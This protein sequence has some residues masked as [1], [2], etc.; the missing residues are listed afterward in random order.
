MKHKTKLPPITNKQ[1]LILLILYKFRFLTILQLQKYFKHKDPHRIKAWLKDLKEKGYA[2]AITDSK[3]I[4]KPYIYCLAAKSRYFLQEEGCNE[5]FLSRIYKEKKLTGTF[6]NHCLF[7]VDIYLFFSS[8]QENNSKLNFCTKQDLM[9][10]DYLP[11]DLDAYIEVDGKDR[12]FLELFDEYRQAP[13]EARFAVR[14]YIEYSEEGSWQANTENSA[15]PTLLFVV[16]DERRRKHL[17]MYGKAKLAKTF[18]DIPL[19]LTTQDA[20]R[21]SKDKTNIWKEA[22]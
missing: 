18:Q 4:T 9:G 21:F 12:Y 8:Q 17:Y 14:K 7:I 13:G 20:I 3:N 16:A 5:D 22:V 19:F 6:I 1:K 11:E 2:Y 10:F 15:F